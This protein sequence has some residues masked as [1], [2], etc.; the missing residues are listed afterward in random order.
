MDRPKWGAVTGE[1]WGRGRPQS[2][3]QQRL[4][5]ATDLS[6]SGPG[7]DEVIVVEGKKKKNDPNIFPVPDRACVSP[8]RSL[9]C[10]CPASQEDWPL[11]AACLPQAPVLAGFCLGVAN[12]SHWWDLGRGNK[13]KLGCFSSSFSA[14]ESPTAAGSPPWLRYPHGSTSA[15]W[16]HPLELW[17][18]CLCP[19]SRGAGRGSLLALSSPGVSAPLSPA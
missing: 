3:S 11:P 10:P 4:Q 8:I 15:S 18:C 17:K 12:G 14:S 19:S 13:G 9:A 1:S 6:W 5:L 16:P 2:P 7:Q